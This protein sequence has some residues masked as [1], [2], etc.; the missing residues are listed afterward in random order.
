MP[1]TPTVASR[2]IIIGPRGSLFKTLFDALPLDSLP[3]LRP[4]PR[5]RDTTQGI[6]APPSPGLRPLPS[7][8]LSPSLA[9][10]PS[11]TN[12]PP[13]NLTPPPRRSSEQSSYL[14]DS[15]DLFS[16][17][18]TSSFS[19]GTPPRRMSGTGAGRLEMRRVA[20]SS[21]TRDERYR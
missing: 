15:P 8:M 2:P 7:P 13:S 17:S 20:S 4:R 19:L 9:R 1:N 12:L 3:R 10:V 21:S 18:P 11:M 5:R 16:D 6:I 14:S